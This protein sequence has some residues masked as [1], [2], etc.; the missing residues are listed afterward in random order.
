[1]SEHKKLQF[2]LKLQVRVHK[3]SNRSLNSDVI[4]RFTF[5]IYLYLTMSS[6]YSTV[7]SS[8]VTDDSLK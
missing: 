3:L 1:M 4:R 8:I 6:C 2:L 5:N 7:M